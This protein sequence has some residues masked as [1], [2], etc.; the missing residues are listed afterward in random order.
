MLHQ[1][2]SNISI[3]NAHQ[4][5]RILQLFS[6]GGKICVLMHNLGKT[7]EFKIPKDSIDAPKP[8]AVAFLEQVLFIQKELGI[9]INFPDDG[10]FSQADIK[11][12]NEIV[13]IIT[14]GNNQDSGNIYT[15]GL[16]K[17]GVTQMVETVKESS[18]IFFQVHSGESYIK[19]FSKE[20]YLGPIIQKIKGKIEMPLEEIHQWLEQAKDKDVLQV[21][22]INTEIHEEFE[23]WPKREE[24]NKDNLI[25]N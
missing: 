9:E 7:L 24:E 18:S 25:S 20:I 17:N 2:F 19:L 11:A 23:N 21:R 10:G 12:A 6:R 3:E 4:S 5:M 16:E 22:V 13:G 8:N 1:H 15:L 14:N